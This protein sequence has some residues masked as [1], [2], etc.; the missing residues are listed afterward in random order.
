MTLPRPRYVFAA[1]A[2]VVVAALAFGPAPA[3][4]EPLPEGGTGAVIPLNAATL[5]C[6]GLAAVSSDSQTTLLSA[7]SAAPGDSTTAS[8]APDSLRI[9]LLGSA[10][11]K[12]PLLAADPG[13][14]VVRYLLPTGP[15]RTFVVRATGTMAR[16]L[17]AQFIT[18]TQAGPGRSLAA[19]QCAAPGGDFWFVGG[20]ATAGRTT[21]LLLTNVDAAPATV[22]VTVYGAKGPVNAAPGQ[23]VLVAPGKQ[24]VL[25]IDGLSP[26]EA[27]TAIR[28]VARSGRFAAS[29]FDTQ[30]KGLIPGG[31]DWIP[32][33]GGPAR[34]LVVPAIAGDVGVGRRLSLVAPGPSDAV[35]R[36]GIS[37]SDGVLV[38]EGLDAVALPAGQIVTVDLKQVASAGPIGLLL[39]SD[40]PVVAGVRVSRGGGATLPDFAYSTS[41]APLRNALVL[42]QVGA[43]A[44][45][46]S[47]LQ[48]TADSGSDAT[49]QVLSQ[50][51]RGPAF[52]PTTVT[53]PA[54]RTVVVE[55][56]TGFGL[57]GTLQVTP[58]PG[59]GP[60]YAG[61]TV[62]QDGPRGPLMSSWLFIGTPL[63][64]RIPLVRPDSGLAASG[65]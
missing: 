57:P 9:D 31:A 2:L 25:P 48:L 41:V 15:A 59:S 28:A 49:V 45:T 27:A 51:S 16:G 62:K 22:D 60:V 29:M 33:S 46:K 11:A 38:P 44:I 14:R 4:K 17:S 52:P 47:T 8:T 61:V 12:K 3:A 10:L 19:G 50:P 6:P 53:I 35:V 42:T 54:G 63:S 34:E 20:G 1:I 64:I 26:G 7:G 18:R 5:V 43:S 36:V 30:A 23:G 21:T 58:E 37:T 32:Q 13:A 24:V 65:G 56:T 39:T 40:Q 55:L